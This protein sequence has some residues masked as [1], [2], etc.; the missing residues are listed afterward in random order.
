MLSATSPNLPQ[1]TSAN[2]TVTVAPVTYY[3]SPN[4]SD[5]N[6]GLSASQAWL[7]PDHPVNCGDTIIAASG[8]SYSNANFIQRAMG[9]SVCPAANNVAW[10]KCATFDACKITYPATIQECYVDN[11]LIGECKVGKSR[12]PIAPLRSAFGAAPN[13]QTPVT[14]HHIIFANDVANGCHG[15]RL[16]HFQQRH[17]R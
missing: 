6:S 15:G 1:A 17:N 11:E 8:T 13:Y 2:F 4:G 3:L 12:P 14:I 7:S 5:S 10:L 9:N 16:Y